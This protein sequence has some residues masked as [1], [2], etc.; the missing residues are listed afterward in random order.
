MSTR[1]VVKQEEG[2]SDL[3][4]AQTPLQPSFAGKAEC[5]SEHEACCKPYLGYLSLLPAV[6]WVSEVKESVIRAAGGGGRADF[7][8][9]PSAIP[10]QLPSVQQFE[11]PPF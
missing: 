2:S 10:T 5:T 7:R 9:G 8:R 6:L 3:I 11:V 1:P 4:S